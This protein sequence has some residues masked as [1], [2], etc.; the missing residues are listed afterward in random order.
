MSEQASTAGAKIK[1]KQIKTNI[2]ED[3]WK[4]ECFH[5]NIQLSMYGGGRG[6]IFSLFF[7]PFLRN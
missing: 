6:K 1:E 7:I 2:R 3:T 5:Q 4:Q